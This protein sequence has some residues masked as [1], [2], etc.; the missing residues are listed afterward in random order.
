MN[1]QLHENLTAGTIIDGKYRVERIIGAGGMG[2]VYEATQIAID[3]KVAVKLL[4]RMYCHDPQVVE[5]FH[6]EAR[7]A[8]SIGH[9]NICEVTDLGAFENGAPYLVMPVL[10]G[11]SLAEV[12]SD[13]AHPLSVARMG[14]IICQTL[15]A[16]QAAHDAGIVHRDLKPDNIFVTKY[17]DREDFVKLLDFGISKVLESDSVSNLTRTGTVV[18][19]PFYMAPEQAKG[20]KDIDFSIDIYAI[21][22]I[23]YE[24][25]VGRRPYDGD[26]YNEI[27]FRIIAE[28]FAPP[29][30]INPSIPEALEQVILKAMSREPEARYRNPAQMREA[31]RAAL[32]GSP[33]SQMSLIATASTAMA[34]SPAAVTAPEHDRR[35]SMTPVPA[36]ASGRWL[37]KA[38]IIA[39]VLVVAAAAVVMLGGSDDNAPPVTVPLTPPPAAQKESP[40][41]SQAP[42]PPKTS[43]PVVL[44]TA[45][46]DRVL[47]V[48]PAEAPAKAQAPHN[49]RS[50]KR[51]HSPKTTATPSPA[52]APAPSPAPAAPTPAP[53]TAPKPTPK[54]NDDVTGRQ[55]TRLK[56]DYD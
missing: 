29:R 10:K 28:P 7:L 39:A 9:D 35:A 3:R 52:P 45:K 1:E 40:P 19:T 11:N 47:N 25:L 36:R 17:G 21:G 4:H 27:M 22:V 41:I 20:S 50:K 5:R 46:E 49:K 48:P 56:L 23:I 6:R 14:D 38:V 42:S 33:S 32:D 43:D 44:P 15:S 54:H 55:G 26:S 31:L 51:K 2:A 8:G 13:A 53:V 30:Q 12:L 18:G 16:L 34:D 37:I 24:V